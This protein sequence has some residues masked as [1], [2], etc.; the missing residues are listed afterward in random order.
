[1]AYPLYLTADESTVFQSLPDAVR[2][3]WKVEREERTY[4]DSPEKKA[5]RISL[6]RLHDRKL[7]DFQKKAQTAQSDR[8]LAAALASMDLKG[9]AED[10][11]A[12]LFFALGPTALSM[13][14]AELLAAAKNDSDLEDIASLTAIRESIL[15]A[16]SR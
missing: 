11:L 8:E 2:D 10:D 7:L 14:I 15:S 13:L 12:E 3:G 6:M 4:A 5:T 1:M 16:F 9:V